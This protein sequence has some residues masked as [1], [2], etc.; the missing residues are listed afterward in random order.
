MLGIN[1]N[2]GGGYHARA[3]TLQNGTGGADC[4]PPAPDR[5]GHVGSTST[6]S[7]LSAGALLLWRSVPES[8]RE[9]A[10]KGKSD[11]RD[12]RVQVRFSQQVRPDGPLGADYSLEK[13][14]REGI[15]V[16]LTKERPRWVLSSYAPGKHE[17][18]LLDGHDLSPEELRLRFY[19]ARAAGNPT[20]YVRRAI[21]QS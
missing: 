9:L 10:D 12:G 19:A 1:D 5:R 16:D 17:K 6:L 8:A 3:T 2:N 15:Q 20:L 18:N 13:Y 21:L 4:L 7:L 11:A 14:S